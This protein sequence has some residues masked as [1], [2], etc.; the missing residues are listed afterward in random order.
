MKFNFYVHDCFFL[1]DHDDDFFLIDEF[2]K[3]I[4]LSILINFHYGDSFSS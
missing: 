2:I 3:L 1:I 4:Y